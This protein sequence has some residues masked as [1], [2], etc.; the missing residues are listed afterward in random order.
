MATWD[1]DD[2][3]AVAPEFTATDDAVVDLWIAYAEPQISAEVF[4][5]NEKLAG[6]FLTAHFLTLFAPSA[7]GSG[8]VGVGP[9]TS[10]RVGQVGVTYSAAQLN[11]ATLAGG[12]GLTKY[13]I[14]FA[15]LIDNAAPTPMVL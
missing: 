8:A 3:R 14:Q 2:V 6:I 7:S 11:S 5:S 9:V 10:R 13:G 15:R 4:A 1:K 12:L